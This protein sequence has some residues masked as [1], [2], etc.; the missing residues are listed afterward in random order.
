MT[1]R[2]GL[3]LGRGG[4]SFEQMKWPFWFGLGGT[5]GSG[6]QLF[7][8]IHVDDTVGI[9]EHVIQSDTTQGILNAV[10]PGIV[11]NHEFTKALGGAMRRPTIFGIPA[12]VFQCLLHQERATM[13]LQGVNVAP[14]RTLESGYTF[15]YPDI[16]SAIAE[17]IQ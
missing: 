6:D 14:K 8:W 7:P 5:I 9:I 13:L 11:T 15:K 1:I 4:G 12:F 17:L 3:V 16:K 2:I 10:A